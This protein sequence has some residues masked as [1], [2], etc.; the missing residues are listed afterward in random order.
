MTV[1][2]KCT[3]LHAVDGW[4]I[5]RDESDPLREGRECAL[6]SDR[7]VEPG[8]IG[9]R[10]MRKPAILKDRSAGA[11]I[12]PAEIINYLGAGLVL[13]QSPFPS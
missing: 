3:S 6:F 4:P 1:R 2:S 7:A 12:F 9:G 13:Q 11:R 5:E 10:K 8:A